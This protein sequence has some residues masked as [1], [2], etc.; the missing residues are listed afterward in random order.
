MTAP[1]TGIEAFKT[2]A[3]TEKPKGFPALLEA[4]KG[5]V[6]KALPEHLRKNIDRYTRV[7]LTCFRQNPK[8]ADCDP[9]S[10]FAAVI[11]SG[12]L[13]LELGVLGQ[14][15]LVP[16]KGEATFVPGWR[17]YV[18]LVH[19]SG[20]AVAWTGAV[21]EGDEFDYAM[22]DA[23]FVKHKPAGEDDPAKLTHTYA[24]GRI[25]GIDWPIIEV[26]TAQRIAKHLK[27]YN[28]VGERHY[29]FANYEM[30]ARKIALLQVIKYL[31]ASV[32]LG[33]L[34]A[35]DSMAESAKGQNLT[36]KDAID[37]AFEAVPMEV[38]DAP[39]AAPAQS[40]DA[41]PS[42]PSSAPQTPDEIFAAADDAVRRKDFDLARD[43]SNKL[44]AKMKAM[45]ASR[46]PA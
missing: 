7:A 44:P 9:R 39:P 4:Y 41:A 14:A 25:R 38:P 17:G 2:A 46:I 32:E 12:Q 24:I 35:L 1:Q 34:I 42:A 5:E 18:D 40:T 15:Y 43:L 36:V 10:V 29:A 27:R 37:G 13:G 6:A 16:Y 31:P 33:Q 45:I 19:R 30:Y 8:L 26:F 20:R 28:K 23:P 3:T 21:F 11:L 22:G